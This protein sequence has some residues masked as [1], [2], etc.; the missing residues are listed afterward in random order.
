[1]S[2]H[3]IQIE[4]TLNTAGGMVKEEKAELTQKLREELLSLDVETVDLVGAGKM[5][6]GAKGIDP[7]LWGQLLLSLAASGGVLTTLINILPDW[8]NRHNQR[9][10][11]LK[12]GDDT[13][14]VTGISSEEQQEL[15]DAWLNRHGGIAIAKR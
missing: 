1:M 4:L 11:T 10:V 12:I 6:L 7:V 2:N 8:L 15:I 5:P 3:S 13:L 9:S 14:E